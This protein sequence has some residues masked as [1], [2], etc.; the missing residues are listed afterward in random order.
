MAG[1]AGT[2]DI[3]ASPHCNDEY[4]FEPET[5]AARIAEL[6]S[7]AGESPVIHFGCDFHLNP[8]NIEDALH[9]PGKYSIDH[10][11][12]L[13]VEFSDYLIPKTTAEIFA[14]LIASGL[15]PIITH[16][17][18]NAMLRRRVADLESWVGQ[19]CIIQVTAQSLL[20]S[21]GKSAR[22]ASAALL[23]RG[24]VHVLASDGHDLQHRPPVLR[25]AYEHVIE[26]YGEDTAARLCVSNPRAVLDG[27][28]VELV[29]APLKTRHWYSP[30]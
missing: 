20:G 3:V 9:S 1:A 18:R 25:A 12:Y 16:P 11:G 5:V 21:F 27:A 29:A 19:G 15:R 30:W 4:R 10:R 23:N 13:L 24:L 14:A 22:D 17:E 26:R 8:E 6:Q 7:A 28:P 2:T